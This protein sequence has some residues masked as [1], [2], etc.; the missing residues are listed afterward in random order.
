MFVTMLLHHTC[1][2]TCIYSY[3]QIFLYPKVRGSRVIWAYRGGSRTAATPKM[4]RFVVIIA[5]R[6]IFQP[7]TIIAKRS[8]LDV[9]AVIDD[10]NDI[11]I[12]LSLNDINILFG[13]CL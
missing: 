13:I 11:N 1:Y 8:I 5:K 2:L 4:E 6:S 3:A 7:S 9:A 10:L 12:L